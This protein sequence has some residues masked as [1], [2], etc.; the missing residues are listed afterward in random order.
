MLWGLS[1]FWKQ[2]Q[3]SVEKQ[4]FGQPMWVPLV[5]VVRRLLNGA[6]GWK[7]QFQTLPMLPS[8]PYT[9]L[10]RRPHP[11]LCLESRAHSLKR[12]NNQGQRKTGCDGWLRCAD[13]QHAKPTF[14][15]NIN[16]GS[17]DYRPNWGVIRGDLHPSVRDNECAQITVPHSIKP[18][19]ICFCQE[20]VAE[21]MLALAQQ[22]KVF[23]QGHLC[24]HSW[25]HFC[26]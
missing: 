4:G 22:G 19:M 20:A 3:M 14:L 18:I 11:R 16:A 10:S 5:N 24:I 8:A 15:K 6:V 9:P 23:E 21:L 2:R 1:L 17:M 26:Y 13:C 7:C 12:V 25:W